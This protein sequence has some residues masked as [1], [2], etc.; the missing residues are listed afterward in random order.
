[1]PEPGTITL[2]TIAALSL[3]AARLNPARARNKRRS[4]VEDC[5]QRTVLLHRCPGRRLII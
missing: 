2:A 4:G 5:L 3:L 1:V